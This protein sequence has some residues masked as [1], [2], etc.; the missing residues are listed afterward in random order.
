MRLSTTTRA[1]PVVATLLLALSAAPAVADDEREYS[2]R[3]DG[4]HDSS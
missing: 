1:A 2:W 3:D 4:D